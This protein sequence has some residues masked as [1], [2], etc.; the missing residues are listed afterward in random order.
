MFDC[1]AG[2]ILHVD[3]SN[4]EIWSVPLSENWVRNYIGGEGFGAI[5]LAE[6]LAKG[7]DGL[8]AENK[9]LFAC[10]PL[11]DTKAPCCGRTVVMFKSPLTGT[12]G[13]SNV[14]GAWAPQLKRAGFDMLVVHGQTP[15]PTYLSINNDEITLHSAEKVW[16]K[17][18]KETTEIIRQELGNPE[19][20]I[21]CIGEAGE[22]LVRFA[23][24]MVGN[25]HAAGRGGGGAVMGAKK[26]KAIA[27]YG[28][29]A[30]TQ[31]HNN[32][33]FNNAVKKAIQELHNEAF[34]REELMKYGTPSFFDAMNSLGLVPAY[35][36]QR[37]TTNF[38]D[39][40]GH[41]AYHEKLEVKQDRC[42]NCPIG[43]VRLTRIP[44]GKYEG[45][46]GSGPEYE[47]L[48][49]F[50]QK[51]GNKDLYSI[52]AANYI[53]NDLGLDIISA[54]Q[55]IATAME[56]YEK[57]IIDQNKTD[58][59]VLSWG[60]SDAI[61]EIVERIARRQGTFA[62]L[63]GEGSLRAAQSIGGDAE[64]YVMHV[65]GQ[66]MAADGVRSSKGEALS[67]ML[68]PRGA[69][70]LR[71]YGATF[72]AFGYLEEEF[73]VTER[74]DPFSEEN[75]DWFKPFEELS[76]ATNLLGVCL[77]ASITLAVK[78]RTWAELFSNG[79]G[80]KYS[81]IDLFKASERVINIERL[82]NIRE[83]FSKK[84]DYLPQRF[85]TGPAP[86][87]PGKG[88][89]VDQ[90]KLLELVYKIKGW[91]SQGVPTKEKLSELDL[92]EIGKKLLG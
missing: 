46:S 15:N 10:G 68:S 21:A 22:K 44:K 12:I 49:A 42:Y 90:D 88:Q 24:I 3:L 29:K 57:G 43:C 25:E 39:S 27:V 70:H 72:D 61:V 36:W 51:L 9:L 62:T 54:G 2:K 84:D 23:T 50:G 83:G 79:S 28:T 91:D 53:A 56:W 86:D 67:H 14:G 85:S 8:S 34:I 45:R 41:K 31:I 75:K 35:N 17:T 89:V 11:T 71:P 60:N 92:T 32:D 64:K 1:Y 66:E 69:D 30:R 78:G 37:T 65:K 55:V 19:A 87:G 18:T 16:G 20:E 7:I 76:M 77:F 59:L 33:Q 80:R 52:V 38:N 6:S 58:G 5:Y 48:A 73:G 47:T 82:F 4:G 63:L 81:Y 74:V 40:L 26:L 13:A